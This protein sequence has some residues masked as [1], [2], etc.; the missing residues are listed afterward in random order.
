MTSVSTVL[1]SSQSLCPIYYPLIRSEM[2]MVKRK[3]MGTK[4]KN[5]GEHWV[6]VTEI[7][8]PKGIPLH[9]G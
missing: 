2:K 4:M 9:R 5:P 1:S 8:D 7:N 3:T 6:A